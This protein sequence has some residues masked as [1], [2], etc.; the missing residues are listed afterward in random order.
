MRDD[1]LLNF[2]L[3]GLASFSA[4]LLLGQH[5]SFKMLLCV[6]FSCTWLPDILCLLLSTTCLQKA[7][8][9]GGMMRHQFADISGRGP[10]EEGKMEDIAR[11]CN[12]DTDIPFLFST[13]LVSES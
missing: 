5:K 10:D 1:E 12:Q 4:F 6:R 9:E 8:V 2:F 3:E 13:K 7:L 11:F